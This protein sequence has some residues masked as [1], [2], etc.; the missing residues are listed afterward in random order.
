MV[1]VV[2]RG[3]FRK[4]CEERLLLSLLGEEVEEFREMERR[5][6]RRASARVEKVDSGV[7]ASPNMKNLIKAPMN[8]TTDNWPKRKPCVKEKLAD[9]QY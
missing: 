4:T 6:V 7:G 9:C 8:I 5:W 2:R 1:A 3:G